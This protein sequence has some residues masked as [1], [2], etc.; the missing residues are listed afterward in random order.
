VTV[1]LSQDKGGADKQM[2]SRQELSSQVREAMS[3]DSLF[4]PDKGRFDK[5]NV[6]FLDLCA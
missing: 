1:Y 4:V 6:L 2:P 3:D 5:Q